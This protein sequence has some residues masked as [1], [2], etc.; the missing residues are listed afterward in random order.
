MNMPEPSKEGYT[1]STWPQQVNDLSAEDYDAM[2]E[3]LLKG[4]KPAVDEKVAI[5]R[6]IKERLW[7][8]DVLR[9]QGNYNEAIDYYGGLI[10]LVYDE[11]TGELSD[12]E[13]WYLSKAF[14]D[15]V[16]CG[17]FS[18]KLP[19]LEQEKE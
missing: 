9:K 7:L 2:M 6:L 4:L 8:A 13:I 14:I 5:R 3:G 1:V 10:Q 15:Y 19:L 18:I 17:R 12:A 16:D 11:A